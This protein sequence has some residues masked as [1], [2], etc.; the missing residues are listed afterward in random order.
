MDIIKESIEELYVGVGSVGT[1]PA[2]LHSGKAIAKGVVIRA[3]AKVLAIGAHS[4]VTYDTGYQLAI[5]ERSPV[6]HIDDLSKV[7]VV[8]DA[9]DSDYSWIAQ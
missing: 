6:I 4:G 2:Q 1:T 9:A 3:G 7:W 8:G 5:G